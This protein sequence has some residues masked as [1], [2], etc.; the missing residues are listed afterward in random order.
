VLPLVVGPNVGA[1]V[2]AVG[3]ILG[4]YVVNVGE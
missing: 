2:V 3:V 1:P 4:E